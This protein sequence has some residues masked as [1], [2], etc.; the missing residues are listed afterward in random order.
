MGSSEATNYVW[1][2]RYGDLGLLEARE[3]RQLRDENA[4]PKRLV[5]DL[6]LDR[7]VLQEVIEKRKSSDAP[8]TGHRAMD[9][10]LSPDKRTTLVPAELPAQLH[11]VLPV[12]G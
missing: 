12:P 5:A 11:V 6:T 10:R 4:R 8:T 2:K 1:K 9:P 3:L 7:H